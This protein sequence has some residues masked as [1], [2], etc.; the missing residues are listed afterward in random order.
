MFAIHPCL[1]SG[2]RTIELKNLFMELV[3]FSREGLMGW[4]R[5]ITFEELFGL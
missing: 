5:R 2:T 1:S 4:E 3:P